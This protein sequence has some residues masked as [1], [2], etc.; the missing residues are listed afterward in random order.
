MF[1]VG[2]PGELPVALR[3][4]QP[5][6]RSKREEFWDR[7]DLQRQRGERLDVVSVLRE[8]KNEGLSFSLH[9]LGSLMSSR[10]ETK[11]HWSSANLL[12]HLV[13]P[14]LRPNPPQAILDVWGSI[15]SIAP[16]LIEAFRPPRAVGLTKVKEEHSALSLLH[17]SSA[18]DWRLADPLIALRDMDESFDVVVGSPRGT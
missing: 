17:E 12:A 14:Y 9:E 1:V 16:R 3:S 6:T 7:L 11:G 8:A 5:M 13:I 4:H 10:R 18:I 2:I 15:G